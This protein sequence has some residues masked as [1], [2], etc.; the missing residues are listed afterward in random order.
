YLCML[1]VLRGFG[2]AA[3]PSTLNFGVFLGPLDQWLSEVATQDRLLR[4]LSLFTPDSRVVTGA[5]NNPTALTIC[6]FRPMT[7]LRDFAIPIAQAPMRTAQQ[8]TTSFLNSTLTAPLPSTLDL[9]SGCTATAFF[10]TS[11][12]KGSPTKQV[13]RR[14]APKV[15]IYSI[16]LDK[17][18]APDPSSHFHRFRVS[19][20]QFRAEQSLREKRSKRKRVSRVSPEGMDSVT[21][22]SL[23]GALLTAARLDPR[24]LGSELLECLINAFPPNTS[25]HAT[26]AKVITNLAR[27]TQQSTPALLPI[28]MRFAFKRG[29][30]A[31][32][33]HRA[34]ISLLHK[35]TEVAQ[36]AY[37]LLNQM[38]LPPSVDTGTLWQQGNYSY[39]LAGIDWVTVSN[40]RALDIWLE[41]MLLQ[42]T[43]DAI[44]WPL[45]RW[46]GDKTHKSFVHLDRALSLLQQK[47]FVAAG[48]A[49]A[50]LRPEEERFSRAYRKALIH[51]HR[52]LSNW[53]E[54]Q[55]MLD[56]PQQG[57]SEVTMI[58]Q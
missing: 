44:A 17:L 22:A 56:P 52:E 25:L 20:Q 2:H 5:A 9:D 28:L 53:T 21:R 7:K 29:L 16:L 6:I 57:D 15:N 19:S 41:A 31:M 42:N 55:H 13:Y 36:C 35:E 11:E 51:C 37:L 48:N 40:P 23:L 47:D 8:S 12:Q 4:L 24:G 49:F 34:L 38:M 45:D 39:G 46:Y 58:L 18:H 30:Q 10:A 33:D 1:G 26:V 43:E 54:L 50:Q 32:L 14:L 3:E 27:H